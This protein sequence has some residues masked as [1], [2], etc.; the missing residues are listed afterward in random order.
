MNIFR[1][2]HAPEEKLVP[3]VPREPALDAS[4]AASPERPASTEPPRESP[5]DVTTPTLLH[6]GW[7]FAGG[8][9]L[10]SLAFAGCAHDERPANDVVTT[11]ANPNR[12]APPGATANPVVQ[13]DLRGL[14]APRDT[15]Y[16]DLRGEPGKPS[17][18]GVGA[19]F[20]TWGARADAGT[21]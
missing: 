8:V 16:R 5:R 11:N 17:N 15:D 12:A 2:T 1:R 14:N 19:D 9:G 18:V 21:K 6:F 20:S 4:P 13:D 7:I 3:L 10:A